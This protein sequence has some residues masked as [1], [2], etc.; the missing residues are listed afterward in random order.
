MW[1]RKFKLT[2]GKEAESV[3]G[4][5]NMDLIRIAELNQQ[6]YELSQWLNIY[7]K[8]VFRSGD[9]ENCDYVAITE[10]P[11]KQLHLFS[12]KKDLMAFLSENKLAAYRYR[13]YEDM[14]YML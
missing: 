4:I 11:P 8:E 9:A 12:K 5:T 3:G 13:R 2:G 14:V 7:A 1:K 10:C 6:K